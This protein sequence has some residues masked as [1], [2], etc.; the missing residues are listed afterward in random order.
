MPLAVM[1]RSVDVHLAPDVELVVYIADDGLSAAEREKVAAA[2][3][4][5]CT[6]RWIAAR[7]WKRT[8][9]PTWGRMPLTTYQKLAIGDWLPEEVER[10]IWLDCDLLVLADLS[11]LWA[12]RN[13][14]RTALAAPDPLV[15]R[16]GSRFG[17]AA[18]RELGL[19]ADAGYFN[20]G[21]LVIDLAQWR[22]EKVA[23]RAA[24][25][26]RRFSHRVVFWDQEALNAVLAGRWGELDSR[27][28]LN[29]VLQC[30]FATRDAT[31]EG[32]PWIAHFS[33][34]LKPW[35][36]AGTSAFQATFDSYLD[37]TPWTGWRPRRTWRK[38]AL[39]RY[40]TSSLRRRLFPLEQWWTAAIWRLT[41]RRVA[42][43]LA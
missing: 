35:T 2:L 38:A 26:L 20:A 7:P 16:L 27:W 17:V 28:N 8:T 22:R 11:R 41:R 6:L 34:R 5:R 18:W 30:L 31:S 42:D 37:S 29:P 40:S 24:D 14:D 15:P 4:A 43:G 25:Y 39:A 1:L 3:S 36:H 33:G 10:V 32:A 13:G 12:L 9:L 23:E 19:A 21:V